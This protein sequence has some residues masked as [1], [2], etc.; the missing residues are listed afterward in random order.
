[1]A[2]GPFAVAFLTPKKATRTRPSSHPN[3]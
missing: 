1:L 2:S 3:G